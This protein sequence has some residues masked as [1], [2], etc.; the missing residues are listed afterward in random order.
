MDFSI[1]IFKMEPKKRKGSS[2]S[3]ERIRVRSTLLTESNNLSRVYGL[4][5]AQTVQSAYPPLRQD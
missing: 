4:C 2:G 1:A 5:W 3:K